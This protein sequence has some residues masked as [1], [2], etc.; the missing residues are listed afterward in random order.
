MAL[1]NFLSAFD[2]GTSTLTKLDVATI[3]LH[4][5]SGQ[6]IP[7]TVLS[8]PYN[9]CIHHKAITNL[10]YLEGL[11]PAHP[12]SSAEQLKITLLIGADQYEDH[13][14]RGNGPTTVRSKL[15]Y[16]L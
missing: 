15:V 10:H 9:C 1:W 2:T 14:I 12:I 13:V 7:L 11:Q 5:I 4:G 8:Y 3:N 6:I 16:L